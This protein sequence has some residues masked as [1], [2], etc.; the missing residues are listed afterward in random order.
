[1]TLDAD[2]FDGM[3][4]DGDDPWGFENRWYEERKRA[5]TLAMLPDRVYRSGVE[6]GCSIGVLTRALASRCERLIATDVSRTAVEAA[7]TRCADL[8]H[9]EVR[10]TAV[11]PEEEC[12]LAV[13]SEVL[14]YFSADDAVVR[15]AQ[16]ARTPTVLGVHWRHP[17]EDYPLGGDQAHAVLDRACKDN[18]HELVASYLDEDVVAA[19]WSQDPRSVA[20]REGLL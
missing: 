17:V 13:V 15:A 11:W 6:M 8:A 3:Y 5:L 4:A 19:V 18:G 2:Y 9:V 14:Y 10:L 12:D 1:M 7:R 20:A 16:V